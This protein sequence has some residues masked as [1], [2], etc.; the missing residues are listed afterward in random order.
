MSPDSPGN[1]LGRRSLARRTAGRML[2]VSAAAG[3]FDTTAG[4]VPKIQ[5]PGVTYEPEGIMRPARRALALEARRDERREL[6]AAATG[7]V[8]NRL[9]GAA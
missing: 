2:H 4:P 8:P 9:R 7:G 3:M 1:G 6:W 5:S